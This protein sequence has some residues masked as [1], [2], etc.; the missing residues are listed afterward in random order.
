MV[1]LYAPLYLLVM[2]TP[3]EFNSRTSVSETSSSSEWLNRSIATFLA[4]WEYPILNLRWVRLCVG[5]VILG[6]CLIRARIGLAGTQLFSHDAFMLLD[7]A[8]RMLNGQRPHIDFYSHL[9]VLTYA[10]TAAA[11]FLSYNRV[12][13]FG[14]AQGL[15][16]LVTGVWT[17]CLGRKRLADT[18]LA[19]MCVAVTFMITDPSALG[20]SPLAVSAGM[21]Y[22]RIGYALTA[23]L[24]IEA[25]GESG[26]AN[27]KDE[28][29]GGASTGAILSILL[30]L[31]ITYFVMGIFL[32]LALIPCRP[33]RKQRW[34]S[35]AVA[36]ALVSSV[37][38]A[39]FGFNM[40][41]ML[42][43]LIT[44]AGAKHFHFDFYLIDN[45]LVWAGALLSFSAAATL[46]LVRFNKWTSS[47]I[48]A[49]V[50]VCLVS[51]A[52]LLGNHEQTGCPLAIFLA[53]VV[54]DGLNKRLSQTHA[55]SGLFRASVLLS[56][57]VL[58]AV[59]LLASCLAF[60]NGL[61]QK[62]RYA[63]HARAIDSPWVYG[64]VPLENN[65]WY[66]DYVDD[67]LALLRKYRHPGETVMSLDFTNPFSY[68][69]G[70]KPA[71]GGTT[72]L[73]YTTTFDDRHRQSSEELFGFAD[74]VMLPKI[75]SDPSLPASI[76]RLYGSYLNIHYTKIAEI[77]Y[78]N[79]YRRK[80]DLQ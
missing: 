7:G 34:M 16:G 2:R 57:S 10:P 47:P 23:L 55:P 17:Y 52:L 1:K 20:F 27:K 18:P 31:K 15:L 42:K 65:G 49:G 24:L 70:I 3:I 13:A 68:S 54:I 60:G 5:L 14:Y 56:G 39:Y 43:D 78:W 62:F 64:F 37:F 72:V 80:R 26:S 50:T 22:N 63:P 40:R 4:F 74:L 9:G 66:A 69:L 12:Q 21:T 11:L 6:A 59:P 77:Y 45:S 75:Y 58:I 44:V 61:V 79:L 51:G 30:F 8:W 46:L 36:F 35:V 76:P 41:P 73:Q 33:Q 25:L 29:W 38:C 19:L 48:I 28:W 53:I 71:R 32:L 67:G